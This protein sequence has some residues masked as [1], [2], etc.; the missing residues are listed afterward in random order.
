[1][2]LPRW[3]NTGRF[4]WKTLFSVAFLAT[5]VLG[6]A[7]F[8]RIWY[9]NA[10]ADAQSTG[11]R[12]DSAATAAPADSHI[13]LPVRPV[14]KHQMLAVVNGQ[15]IDRNQLA[16]EAIRRFGEEVLE[17]LVNK[18][19]I[20]QECQKRGIQIT[21]TEIEAEI[22]HM[23]GKFG[24]SKDRWLQMLQT[25]RNINPQQYRSDIIWPTLALKRLSVESLNVSKDELQ[26]AWE[27]Q[28]GP[29][30]QVRMIMLKDAAR[31]GQLQ[32]Y[33]VSNVEDFG[34]LAKD[35]SQDV[36]SAS[37]R[38]LIPPVRRHIGDPKIEEAVF[39]LK[40]GEVS[41]VVSA[42]EQF[43]I[44]KCEK[45]IPATH[46]APA[47][48]A[49]AKERLYDRLVDQ[50]LRK[51]S[52]ELF[53]RLQ[54]G[55]Q[56][57]NIYN[58]PKLRE[59]MP[60]VAATINGQPLTIQQLGE[61]CIA[62][63]G[64]EVLEGE[65]NRQLLLQALARQRVKVLQQD[66]DD[67][68]ARAAKLYGF[69]KDDG[70]ADIEAW[71]NKVIKEDAATVDL[72]VQDAVW[73]SVALKK[74]V[75]DDVEVT[76]EDL[77]K[78]YEANYG[79]QV[80]VLIVVLGSHRRAQEVWEMARANPTDD[81]FADLAHQYSIEPTS[82]YNFGKVPPIRRFSGQPD[83]EKEAFQLTPGKLSGIVAVGDKFI[84]MRCVK[85]KKPEGAP[86]LNAVEKEL[87]VD[88]HEK[89]LRIAMSKRFEYLRE[90]ARIDNYLTGTSQSPR[91]T[92]AKSAVQPA[93]AVK[94]V[95]ISNFK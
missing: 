8:W 64:V 67:E 90:S 40:E 5:A 33:L 92:E 56:V 4:R 84:V 62:R 30:V 76:E 73:P 69:M 83:I 86:D 63:H 55:A 26:K 82:K 25:E 59:Q 65:I 48:L 51:A 41:Q 7:L 95:D 66:I 94:P 45:H 37:A 24:L 78:A 46:V 36:S 79:E 89:K 35:E 52:S 70:S 60:G 43:F 80:E 14:K 91:R 54:E 38:G 47:H 11:T 29:Q 6:T 16:S 21:P 27:S 77:K 88:L 1:M 44:F 19:L 57:V 50:K 71:L 49:Q 53:K 32:Q 28:Y 15:Q 9:S 31:A 87:Y 42:A 61:E 10:S 12:A 17:S 72:Y 22:D 74:L 34:K 23:A 75:A 18:H 58:E 2:T 68:V 39:S 85:R 93:S 20:L 3:N 13:P 81:F